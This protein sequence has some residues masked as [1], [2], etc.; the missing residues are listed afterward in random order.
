MSK[1]KSMSG[2]TESECRH[3][4]QEKINKGEKRRK[5]NEGKSKEAVGKL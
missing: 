2:D 1:E 4:F 3:T 5:G